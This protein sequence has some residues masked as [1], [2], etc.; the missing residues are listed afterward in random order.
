MYRIKS[1]PKRELP[2]SNPKGDEKIFQNISVKTPVR[3][4]Y[5]I[6]SLKLR[7]KTVVFI[8]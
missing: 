1:V 6:D 2:S 7:D 3:G 8:Y 4:L 5:K